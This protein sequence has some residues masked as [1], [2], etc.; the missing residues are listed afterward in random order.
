[1]SL[2]SSMSFMLQEVGSSLKGMTLPKIVLMVHHEKT[3]VCW[4][5]F[6]DAEHRQQHPASGL[7]QGA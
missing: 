6:H 4:Y 3:E 2:S 5:R 1:M 7:F